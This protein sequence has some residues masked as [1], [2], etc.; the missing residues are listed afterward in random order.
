MNNK[1]FT[2][3]LIFLLSVLCTHRIIS[4]EETPS[5]SYS[6]KLYTQSGIEAAKEAG[7]SGIG[8]KFFTKIN[9][10]KARLNSM[11]LEVRDLQKEQQIGL[12]IQIRETETEL[13]ETFGDL[14]RFILHKQAS[15]KVNPL[16]ISNA[17]ALL[18]E[19]SE[20]IRTEIEYVENNIKSMRHGYN[21]LNAAELFARNQEISR[22]YHIY[23]RLLDD[24]LENSS[25]MENLKIPVQEDLTFLDKLLQH[26]AITVSG[27]IKLIQEQLTD[28]HGQ[29]HNAS[30]EDK[31]AVL[32][33]I[34]AVEEHK[35]GSLDSLTNIIVL[36]NTR[37][38]KTADYSELLVKAKGQ[39]SRQILDS[40]VAFSLLQ[41]WIEF[42]IKW[43]KG[44]SI[45]I[46]IKIISVIIILLI[47]RLIA[48]LVKRLVK[49]TIG[50]E[51]SDYS[52]L[53]GNF[54]VSISGKMVMILG[55]LVVISQLGIKVTPLLAGLG[56]VG[57]IA[58]FALQDVL[59]NFASGVMIL[60][61]QPFDIGDTIE[62]PDVSGYVQNMNLVSTI[63]LTYDNQKLVVPNNK[64]WG[65]I[66][67]NIHSEPT[68]R[69]DMSFGVS[70]ETDLDKAETVLKNILDE[71][72]LVLSNPPP[73]IKLHTLND[74]S[75]DYIVR[76]WTKTEHYWEVYWDITRSVKKR[77]DKENISIPYPQQ[78]IHIKTGTEEESS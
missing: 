4:A 27:E 60:I 11:R 20:I 1:S 43:L 46:A 41:N 50:R 8:S 49:R 44:N 65:N 59:S 29:Y 51:E 40:G 72:E 5:P 61:Y 16:I 18:I 74:S 45:A 52:N 6:I 31:G 64:I 70:Y 17:E 73:R 69:V 9:N 75:M 58:G 21:D 55:I 77:F 13:R 53:M 2:L 57:F 23:D 24:L 36:L 67:R 25:R 22:K 39:L 54:F 15:G 30:K 76:P 7:S 33:K 14:L 71:H 78:D 66:I 3:T 19:E 28:L 37:G 68:R 10:Y 32:A 63:I 38:M 26:R 48:S 47:F 35:E 12:I 56:I 62:V 42:S 34:N